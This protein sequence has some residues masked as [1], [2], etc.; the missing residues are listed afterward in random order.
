MKSVLKSNKLHNVCYD[1]RGPVLDEARRL[2]EEGHRVLKLN[3]GNPAP[4]GLMAPEEIIQDVIYQLPDGSGYSDSKGLFAGRK[5]VMQYYQARGIEDV[6][7]DDI[8]LGNGVSELIV[9]SMQ[10]LL[11]NGD[12]VLIPA[13]DYPLWTAAVSLS[14]GTPVHYT[15]DE[16][17][18]WY[19]DLD[20]IRS[21]ISDRTRALVI[22]NPNNPTGAVYPKAIL[23]GMIE[24]AREHKLIVFSDEI[25]DKILYD[26]AQHTC[27]ASLAND[28]VFITFNGLSKTYRIAGYR[29]GWMVISGNK[30][31]AKDY[32]EGITMLASMRLCANVPGQLAIQTALG[33]Y[34][35]INELIA[36]D[37]RLTRQR[38]LAHS[39]LCDIPGISCVKPKGALYLFPRL[40]PKVYPIV[41]DQKLVLDLLIQE[42]IL[43]V[44]GS[45][46]N[47]PAPDHLRLV[48]LPREE[49]L[50]TALT[51][52]A[53][54]FE[55]LRDDMKS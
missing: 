22:I 18:D 53:E 16:Q 10:A 20:D 39:M 34:Q 24:I 44:Q 46:F 25:Y 11:N 55:R 45:G 47:W 51:K 6:Q 5:A 32:L 49:D 7:I 48:F 26:E 36:P 40:D 12:E 52:M 3:I 42:K 1:I 54:F 8:F 35:S 14:G 33:G 23:E 27:T 19:P 41:D 4:F 38:N 30:Y 2:E 50:K 21:K 43:L 13:P 29:A 28:L 37:G 15:C 17:S 31:A 9:M